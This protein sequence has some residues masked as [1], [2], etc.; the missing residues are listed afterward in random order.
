MKKEILI[1]AT[2][3]IPAA[4]I[5]CVYT[6]RQRNPGY[7]PVMVVTKGLTEYYHYS[8]KRMLITRVGE[9][10]F[11]LSLQ[12]LNPLITEPLLVGEQIFGEDLYLSRPALY[13]LKAVPETTNQLIGMAKNY[14]KGAREFSRFNEG[15][16]TLPYYYHAVLFAT[17]AKYYFLFPKVTTV[18]R[19]LVEADRWPELKEAYELLGQAYAL[20]S[21]MYQHYLDRAEKYLQA[22]ATQ[23]RLKPVPPLYA[24]EPSVLYSC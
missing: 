21:G 13:D 7:I 6:Y 5:K 1:V 3:V 2:S 12:L 17:F 8:Y 16:L 14:F 18:A 15:G 10:A 23:I 4:Q 22:V 11:Y 9:K 24:A 19:L 20:S